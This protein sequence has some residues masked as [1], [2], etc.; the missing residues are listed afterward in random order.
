MNNETVTISAAEYIELL[1][2]EAQLDF[3]HELG[4]DNWEG[5]S[6]IDDEEVDIIRSEVKRL[7]SDQNL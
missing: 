2:A 3:L 5:F 7:Q 4:V 6:Y 1:I